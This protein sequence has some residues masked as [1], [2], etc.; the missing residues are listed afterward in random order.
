MSI[1]NGA[2][3]RTDGFGQ[4]NGRII[5]RFFVESIVDELASQR[6]G[7][8]IFHDQ[9]RVE[10][11]IPGVSQYN[12][13]VDIVSDD[14]RRRWPEQ[15]R[16]FRAGQELALDGTPLEQWPLLKRSHV[17][18]LKAMNFSTVEQLAEMDDQATQRIMGGMRIRTLAKA[19]IDDAAAGALLAKATADNDRKDAQIAELQSK[20]GELGTLLNQIHGEMQTM[21]NAPNPI[22]AY[23][24]GM[25][26]PVEQAKK[27]PE[28]SRAS[29]L[30]SLGAVGERRRGR[31]PKLQTE[32]M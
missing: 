19:Y 6:E 18:E 31:P 25:H 23:L 9:E 11:M 7:R 1:Q 27:N 26:D 30:D 32:T 2:Y 10:L 17:L 22:A 13:K 29:S 4:D 14:H 12:I 3:T 16:A 21:K 20:V 8:P 24:P 5:P 15:Y 28:P